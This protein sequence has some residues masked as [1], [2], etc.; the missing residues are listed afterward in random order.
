MEN[1][2]VTGVVNLITLKQIIVCSATLDLMCFTMS[3]WITWYQRSTTVYLSKGTFQLH[4]RCVID[5]NCPGIENEK[6]TELWSIIN[7]VDVSYNEAS[8]EHQIFRKKMDSSQKCVQCI[9]G[10]VYN[11]QQ[12]KCIP[13]LCDPGYEWVVNVGCTKIAGESDD[14]MKTA[15]ENALEIASCGTGTDT[16]TDI[17]TG[18]CVHINEK[19]M[20]EVTLR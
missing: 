4:W 18:E 8:S 14:V 6:G 5:Y 2:L 16:F 3:L 9:E 10:S 1:A 19:P 15:V 12:K 7:Y 17:L 20:V 13:T 11:E